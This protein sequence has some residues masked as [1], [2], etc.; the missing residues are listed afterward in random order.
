MHKKLIRVLLVEDDPAAAKLTSEALRDA[1]VIQ[2]IY[3]VQDGEA[4]LEF[5][6]REG[7]YSEAPRP[8]L[9][10]LDLN[11]PKIDGKTLLGRIKADSALTDIPVVVLSVSDNPQDIKDAYQLHAACFITK[12]SELEDYF[13]SVRLLKELWFRVAQLSP[14]TTGAA[15]G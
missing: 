4:A 1:L 2:E 13:S 8:D 3:I 5:L 12:P 15:H 14:D 11:L 6:N 10:L 7:A 9:I